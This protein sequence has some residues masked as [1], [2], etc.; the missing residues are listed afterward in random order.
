MILVFFKDSVELTR[1]V[2]AVFE[3]FSKASG[4]KINKDKTEAMWLGQ[5]RNRNDKP[6]DIKWVNTVKCLGIHF[7]YGDIQSLN[8]VKS[9]DSFRNNIFRH[10]NRETT[11]MGKVTILNYIGYSK[12]WHKAYNCIIPES[13]CRRPCGKTID[14][15]KCLTKLSQGFIWGFNTKEN[16]Q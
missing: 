5:F 10:L 8:W 9:I 15:L 14:I 2:I 3:S 12:L 13:L 7:G 6:I 16:R 11:I 4:S 1:K